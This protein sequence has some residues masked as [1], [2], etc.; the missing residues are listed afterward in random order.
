MTIGLGTLIAALGTVAGIVFGYLGQQR[1]MKKE[2]RE[3]TA[4]SA[5]LRTNLEYIRRGV[6]DIR[7]DL[8]AQENRV[9]E[10]SERVIRVEES[11]KQAHKR[12]D[13]I[14]R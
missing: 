13:N 11:S 14:E 10:L 4:G 7:I 1:A 6:D 2:V 12:L 8:K 5:E 9:G 3:D